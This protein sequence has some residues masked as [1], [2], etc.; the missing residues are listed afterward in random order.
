MKFV[1]DRGLISDRPRIVS[2]RFPDFFKIR[3]LRC[4][5]DATRRRRLECVNAVQINHCII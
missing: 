5:Q 4:M 3:Y 1:L 2:A